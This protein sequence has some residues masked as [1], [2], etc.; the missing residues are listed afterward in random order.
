MMGDAKFDELIQSLNNPE[1]LM[2]TYKTILP[3]FLWRSYNQ[4]MRYYEMPQL[5][6]FDNS[7]DRASLN[8]SDFHN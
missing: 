3:G 6:K 1:K 2:R 7:A 8:F 5:E 4:L